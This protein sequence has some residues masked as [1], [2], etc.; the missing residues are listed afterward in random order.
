MGD[1][2]LGECPLGEEKPQTHPLRNKPQ[3]NSVS[4]RSQL[5]HEVAWKA[6]KG[7]DERSLTGTP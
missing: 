6:V 5:D 7:Q 2:W 4:L 1:D 3:L